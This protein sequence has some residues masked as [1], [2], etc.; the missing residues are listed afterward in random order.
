MAEL[1][2]AGRKKI[3]PK[4]FALS[5]DRYPIHDASHARNALARVSQF[6]TPEEKAKVRAAVH[7]KYPGMG[8][9]PKLRIGNKTY[10]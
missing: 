6:G 10:G 5:G 2:A 1:T 7:H 3:T 8:K 9:K 4:N